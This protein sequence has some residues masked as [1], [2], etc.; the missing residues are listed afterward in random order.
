MKV[1]ELIHRLTLLDPDAD[2]IASVGPWGNPKGNAMRKLYA[3]EQLEDEFS[4]VLNILEIQ[5][6]SIFDY[7][8]QST[9]G[10][11]YSVVLETYSDPSDLTEKDFLIQMQKDIAQKLKDK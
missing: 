2:V 3:K 4:D 7:R 10:T 1:K 11:E 8:Q 5:Q 6:I 9:K